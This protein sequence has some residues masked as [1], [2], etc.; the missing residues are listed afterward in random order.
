MQLE[1]LFEVPP[2]G[3]L[4]EGV[5]AAGL[6]DYLRACE[7]EY[8]KQALETNEGQIARTAARLGISRKNLWERMKRLDLSAG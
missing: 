6:A 1:T 5:T 7:R 3:E 4:L 2:P 8:I